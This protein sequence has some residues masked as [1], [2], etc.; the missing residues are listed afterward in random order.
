MQGKKS[1][2]DAHGA[3]TPCLLQHPVPFAT[4]ASSGVRLN[5]VLLAVSMATDLGLGQPSEHMVRATRLS[6]RIGE[7]LGLDAAQLAVL[8]DVSLLTYVGCPVYGNETALVFGDDIDFRSGSYD[9]DL[10][11]RDGMRYM[12]GR[13]GSGRSAVN[14]LRQIGRLM[15]TGGR[16]VAEQMA[17]HCSVA[18][19]LADQL[20]L[21]PGVRVGIEQSYAR[22]DGK[23]RLGQADRQDSPPESAR[24]SSSWQ[25]GYRTRASLTGSASARRRSGTTWS[26][27]TR[28]WA[29]R[30]VPAL[31][32]S[33]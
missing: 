19:L 15:A 7:K 14:R 26:T 5:E 23:G 32:C 22:W 24:S 13:A 27:S 21:E 10:G 30:T 1:L 28:S 8:Y 33:Q 29:S 18:G 6:M 16:E 12:L 25:A 3:F 2:P 17:N 11:A 31:H 4:V 9:V 20:G